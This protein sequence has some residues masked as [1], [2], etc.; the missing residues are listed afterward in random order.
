MRTKAAAF[1]VVAAFFSG[2]NQGK[3]KSSSAPSADAAASADAEGTSVAAL[4]DDRIP[5]ARPEMLSPPT[6][7]TFTPSGLA[8]KMV[9]PGTTPEHPGP[10]DDVVVTFTGWTSDGKGFDSSAVQGKPARLRIGKIIPGLTEGLQLMRVGEK[11]RLW[12][13]AHLA[14]GDKPGDEGKPAGSLILE[15]E[16]LEINPAPAAPADVAGPPADATKTASGLFSRLLEKGKGTRH[17]KESDKVRVHFTGWTTDGRFYASSAR[18]G[19]AASVRVKDVLKGL[20]EG[21][22]LMVEGEKRR[23]WIPP[24]LAF[25]P[26]SRGGVPAGMVVFDVEL[27]DIE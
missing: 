22:Q 9:Q 26:M 14:Y 12:L 24:D 10:D 23:F 19:K 5:L 11:A 1:L 20:T 27:I 13:P 18:R 3:S 2:C 7:A 4:S 25:G 6:D 15:V 21:L 17:P 8:Y 16:L